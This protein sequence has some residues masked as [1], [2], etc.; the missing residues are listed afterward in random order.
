[1]KHNIGDPAPDFNLPDQNGDSHSLSDFSG[2]WLAIFFY[3][4]DDTP[5][6]TKEACNFRDHHS[7]IQALGAEV[8]GVSIDPVAKHKKFEKKY[9][10]NFTLLAD[11]NKDM[12]EA[13]DVWGLKKFMGK[14]YMGTSRMSF[15][16]NPEGKIAMIYEKVKAAK[17]GTEVL[18]DLKELIGS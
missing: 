11:E 15:I 14:E 13:Y 18:N 8:V 5:G 2:K 9:E 17:H 10:L 1:M 3:P 16:V 12:V 4:K 6:C 7:D